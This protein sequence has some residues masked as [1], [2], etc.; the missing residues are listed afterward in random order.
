MAKWLFLGAGILLLGGCISPK[1]DAFLVGAGM[2]AGL[3]CMVT[4]GDVLCGHGSKGNTLWERQDSNFPDASIPYD[5][6]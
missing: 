5:M 1:A 3:T 2:G 4:K 6:Y